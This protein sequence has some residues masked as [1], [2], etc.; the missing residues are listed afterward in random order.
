MVL[1][2]VD[3]AIENR[4]HEAWWAAVVVL[5]GL[6]VGTHRLASASD[7]SRAGRTSH[8]LRRTLRVARAVSVGAI[9][10]LPKKDQ[11]HCRFA[12]PHNAQTNG[13]GS[14]WQ[15]HQHFRRTTR[16]LQE[17]H[18]AVGAGR[19]NRRQWANSHDPQLVAEMKHEI[20]ALVQEITQL[21]AQ[22]ISP[23]GVL[24]GLSHASRVGDGG[25]RRGGVD[26]RAKA[27]G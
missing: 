25:R 3:Y 16:R 13:Q 11:A 2:A 17:S 6:I 12:L 18:G 26:D 9:L 15:R 14:R 4:S 24:R 1:A 20:R 7:A 22:D 8:T 5:A 19:A 10:R 27:A 23:G 21:A